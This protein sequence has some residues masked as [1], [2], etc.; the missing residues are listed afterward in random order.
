VLQQIIKGVAVSPGVAV[1]PALVVRWEAPAVADRPVGPGGVDGELARLA[2]ALTYARE[3]VGRSRAKAAERAGEEEARIFDAQLMILEDRDLLAGVE[4]LIRENNFSAERAFQL[5]MLEWRGLWA[6]AGSTMLRDRLADLTDIEVRVLTRLLGLE[7]PSLE[8]V[9]PEAPVVLVAHDL[10]PS[11]T[12]QLDRDAVLAIACEQGTRTS[13]AAILAHS[14]GIP[15]VM[16]LP[17][18]VLRVTSGQMVVLD[19]WAGT[20]QVDPSE[21]TIEAAR[22]RDR[23]RR[24]LERDLEAGSELPARSTDGVT[25]TVRANLDLPEELEMA[26]RHGA[27]GLGLVRTEFLVAGRS[28]MPTEDEQTEL[29]R[30][31]GTAF[32]PH[33]VVIRTFDLG[34][35]K[36][37]APFR[38]TAEGNP[39]LGW[40]AIRVCLDQPEIFRPQIR[41]VLR[42]AVHAK[43]RLEIP[44]V[45]RLDEVLRTRALVEEEARALR[46]AGIEAAATVPLGVMVETPAAAIMA[47]RLAEVCDFLSVGTN[48]LV[49]YTLA[50]DRGNARLAERFSAHH[51]A[52][53][54]LLRTIARAARAAKCEVSVCGEMAADP[55]S[56]YLL[57]GLGYRVLSV[58]APSLPLVKWMIRQVS[59]KDAASCAE[60]A[61]ELPTTDE[62]SAFVR[63]TVGS[64]VDLRLLDPASPLPAR[65]RRASFRR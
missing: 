3:R 5:K 52:V 50:V 54:R 48:D 59:V 43:L 6:T 35:D 25:V 44:L 30:R 13:H 20:L 4:R 60:A 15:A 10:T 9:R 55:I 39:M 29:Y 36:F 42:A 47:D 26:L 16:A 62:V 21:Q 12:V 41:A 65:K 17:D 32:L 8:Q 53:L 61:L 28:Q 63:R 18:V 22:R 1:G 40:R 11:L 51:P 37:P 23:Q 24:E 33:P 31:I 7:E 19:G 58:A 45:T 34:G 38:R 2:D 56:V 14:I 57:L 27:E 49:Q 46:K 64:V